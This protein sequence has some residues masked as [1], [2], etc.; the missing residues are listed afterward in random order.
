[1]SFV[2]NLAPFPQGKLKKT[3]FTWASSVLEEPEQRVGVVSLFR[4]EKGMGNIQGSL[5]PLWIVSLFVLTVTARK[6]KAGL[7]MGVIAFGGCCF[8]P[9]LP[10]ISWIPILGGL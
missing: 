9:C 4:M 6:G 3:V 7:G 2:L 1:M 8:A 10:A 5:E